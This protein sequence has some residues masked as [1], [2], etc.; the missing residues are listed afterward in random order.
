MIDTVLGIGEKFVMGIP[1][2]SGT[3]LR[4]E[5]LENRLVPSGFSTEN[6]PPTGDFTTEMIPPNSIATDSQKHVTSL[7]HTILSRDPDSVGLNGFLLAIDRSMT[8]MDIS[9]AIWNSAESRLRMV[10]EY[11]RSYLDRE[12]DPNGE[13]AWVKAFQIGFGQDA[14]KMGF[15]T[16]KEYLAGAGQGEDLIRDL[17]L[18]ILGRPVQEAGL[19]AQSRALGEFGVRTVVAAILTSPESQ[20]LQIS[21]YYT[22]FLDRSIEDNKEILGLRREQLQKGTSVDE[23]GW[24]IAASTESLSLWV[25]GTKTGLPYLDTR[26]ISASAEQSALIVEQQARI[27]TL[28]SKSYGVG[29]M[30]VEN[31]NGRVIHAFGNRANGQLANGTDFF[32]T[33]P[34][35]HGETQLVKWYFEHTDAIRKSLGYLPSP[36][37][38]TVVTSLDPCAMCA[39]SLITAGFNVAVVAPDDSGG[40]VN[41]DSEF[42]FTNVSPPVRRLLL[43]E[44]GYY[45][46][47]GVDLRSVYKGGNGVLYADQAIDKLAYDINLQAFNESSEIVSQV[48]KQ[49]IKAGAVKN[50][51]TL[52]R[53]SPEILA[54]HATFPEA[55]TLQLTERYFDPL[56]DKS[57]R[58]YFKPTPELYEKL[59]QAAFPGN[60][61]AVAMIDVYGNLIGIR[62][63]APGESPIATALMNLVGDYSQFVFDQISR[64][65][66]QWEDFMASPAYQYFPTANVNSFIFLRAPSAGFTTTLKDLGLFGSTADELLCFIEPPASG[67]I[68]D[69]QDMVRGLPI[70]YRG[71]EDVTPRQMVIEELVIPVTSLAESGEGTLHQAIERANASGHYTHIALRVQ[72]VLRLG[73]DLPPITVPIT[74]DGTGLT[75][76]LGAPG[77]EINFNNHAGFRFASGSA[78]SQV[79]GISFT[80]SSSYALEIEVPGVMAHGNRFGVSLDDTPNPNALGGIRLHDSMRATYPAEVISG[81]LFNGSTPAQRKF[82]PCSCPACL[83][84]GRHDLASWKSPTL[85]L[86]GSLYPDAKLELSGTTNLVNVTRLDTLPEALEFSFTDGLAVEGSFTPTPGSAGSLTAPIFQ[87]A[88]ATMGMDQRW[89]EAEGKNQG[90]SNLVSLAAGSWKPQI[91]L[92][93]TEKVITQSWLTQVGNTVYAEFLVHPKQGYAKDSGLEPYLGKTFRF[94]LTLATPGINERAQ[95]NELSVRVGRTDDQ[96]FGFGFYKVTDGK[97]GA[98]NGLGGQ[99]FLPG[100]VGYL[101]A[102]YQNSL[103]QGSY[104]SEDTLPALGAVKELETPNLDTSKSFGILLGGPNGLAHAVSSYSPVENG[105][106]FPFQAFMLDNGLLGIGVESNPMGGDRDFNDL[107]FSLPDN[108]NL[109]FGRGLGKSV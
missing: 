30:I 37:N 34:S 59:K 1:R 47:T 81:D 68:Q 92:L 15:L 57:D 27:A 16:S 66:V 74:L 71:S 21:R 98:V 22:H 53:E 75:G 36:S 88:L 49:R 19:V 96:I 39:G 11:Y 44:F 5:T 24:S 80:G 7:Y 6:N 108:L 25:G 35:N 38:L 90:G 17:Y 91:K 29:G 87:A 51:A 55:F 2:K 64:A 73:T 104:F 79:F 60:G 61:N 99:S 103:D 67:S 31:S 46:V 48:R 101:E 40:G 102:A 4:L 70:Y 13:A 105:A 83:G 94:A 58:L 107:I 69:F 32:P 56:F 10:R 18:K 109:S 62:A 54:L 77:V 72:G 63:D 9:K 3:N 106:I 84:L 85:T 93:A 43:E 8:S 41:W 26:T 52:P 65:S 33:S 95:S 45:K 82:L 42:T 12:G 20:N 97:T 14:V 23:V 78:G 86:Q 100:E 50:P 89:R 76:P 28:V